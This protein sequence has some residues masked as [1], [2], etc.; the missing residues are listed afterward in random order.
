MMNRPRSLAE[1]WESYRLVVVPPGIPLVV[2]ELVRLA[3]YGG[4]ETVL[5]TTS[6]M[7]EAPDIE[8]IVLLESLYREMAAF[9]QSISHPNREKDDA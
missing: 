5:Q 8:A 9:K 6:Y 1:S 3:F 2:V 7:A 4:V